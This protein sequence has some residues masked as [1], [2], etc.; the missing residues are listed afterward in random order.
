MQG[1]CAVDDVAHAVNP[2]NAEDVKK[3]LRNHRVLL[4]C[5]IYSIIFDYQNNKFYLAAGN[6]PAAEDN[7]KEYPLF[8]KH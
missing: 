7:Y 2:T 6:I 1:H 4:A 3:V 5:N 8:D